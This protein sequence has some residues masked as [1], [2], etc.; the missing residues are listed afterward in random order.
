MSAIISFFRLLLPF[1][2]EFVLGGVSISEGWKN[3]KKR[4]IILAS[5]V[6]M[7]LVILLETRYILD[8]HTEIRD[9]KESSGYTQLRNLKA[10]VADLKIEKISW[11]EQLNTLKAELA[12]CKKTCGVPLPEAPLTTPIPQQNTDRLPIKVPGGSITPLN[13]KSRNDVY[14]D[15]LDRL[16]D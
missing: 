16:N 9:I 5:L 11:L 15:F 4:V 14:G 7:I 2:I 6:I 8:L 3:H 1:L 10:E 13:P 12:A